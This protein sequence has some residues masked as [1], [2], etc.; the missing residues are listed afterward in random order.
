MFVYIITFTPELDIIPEMNFLQPPYSILHQKVG[1]WAAR[2]RPQ[3]KA[4]VYAPAS[5]GQRAS[6]ARRSG[7]LV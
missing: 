7:H 2:L 6:N 5:A 4:F 1:L 3:T